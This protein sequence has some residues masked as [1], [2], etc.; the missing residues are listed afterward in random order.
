[1][2]KHTEDKLKSIPDHETIQDSKE[3]RKRTRYISEYQEILTGG[4]V[5][6]K[7]K[8]DTKSISL[9]QEAQENNQKI[10]DFRK[11]LRQYEEPQSRTAQ[12]ESKEITIEPFNLQSEREAGLI[13]KVGSM[14]LLKE[15]EK[16]EYTDRWLESVDGQIYTP[17]DSTQQSNPKSINI[18]EC[19]QI[20]KEYLKPNETVAQAIKRLR[21]CQSKKPAYKKNV[22]KN[23]QA[24]STSSPDFPQEKFD[25]LISAV[26]DLIDESYL[27]VYEWTL[28]NLNS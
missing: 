27:D 15:R 28:N 6:K 3:R 21:G 24:I 10:S 20:L 2:S 7:F 25:A 8:L 1:M 18:Q 23:A 19:K 14:Y 22:R 5:S 11:D 12:S 9:D 26:S 4:R 16:E 13:D 17:K